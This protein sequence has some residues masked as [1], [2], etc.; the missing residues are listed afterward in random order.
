MPQL[1]DVYKSNAIIY[2][3]ERE[4]YDEWFADASIELKE[5]FAELGYYPDQLVHEQKTRIAVIE[6]SIEYCEKYARYVIDDKLSQNDYVYVFNMCEHC[7][8]LDRETIT[9]LVN[10]QHAERKLDDKTQYR[11]AFSIKYEGLCK[12]L[13]TIEKT[14]SNYQLY[15]INNNA[16]VNNLA[17]N[18][19]INIQYA[20]KHINGK[21]TKKLFNEL[22]MDH[23]KGV[24]FNKCIEIVSDYNKLNERT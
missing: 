11:R 22:V 4:H 21:I 18:A 12:E 19:I 8:N 2:G 5:L 1:D 10:H 6:Y 20:E 3:K 9:K 14:M 13:S 17:I 24:S 16:W 7:P 23:H 15:R